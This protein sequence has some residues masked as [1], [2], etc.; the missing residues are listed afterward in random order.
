MS[1][2]ALVVDLHHFWQLKRKYLHCGYSVISSERDYSRHVE[3]LVLNVVLLKF[4]H[5]GLWNCKRLEIVVVK[6]ET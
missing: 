3:N 2:Y 1:I 5:D 4:G 6:M